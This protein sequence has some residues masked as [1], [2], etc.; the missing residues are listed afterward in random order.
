MP[1]TCDKW[2]KGLDTP[3]TLMAKPSSD[4]SPSRGEISRVIMEYGYCNTVLAVTVNRVSPGITGCG[5]RL[6]LLAGPGY[7]GSRMRLLPQAGGW[8]GIDGCVL[9]YGPVVNGYEKTP[10]NY[11]RRR[12]G[13]VA[14]AGGPGGREKEKESGHCPDSASKE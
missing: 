8:M 9:W 3:V 6:R 1:Q 13:P 2:H 11:I 12:R 4:G 14:W 10:G 5:N 7:G